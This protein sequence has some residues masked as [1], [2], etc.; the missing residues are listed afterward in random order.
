MILVVDIGN[1]NIVFGLYS[2]DDLIGTL[3]AETD[4]GLSSKDYAG[5]LQNFIYAE[6]RNV[7]EI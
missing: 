2:G 6:K 1:T 7:R 5:K 3:R 4:A